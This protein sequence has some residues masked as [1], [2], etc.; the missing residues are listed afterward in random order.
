MGKFGHWILSIGKEKTWENEEGQKLVE[1]FVNH[2]FSRKILKITSCLFFPTL[3]SRYFPQPIKILTL[4]LVYFVLHAIR[5]T[6]GS[7][8]GNAT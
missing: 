5:A 6:F 1:N 2:S 3:L 7:T 4:N 8:N